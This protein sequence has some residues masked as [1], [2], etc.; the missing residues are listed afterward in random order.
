M[1]IMRSR[2]SGLLRKKTSLVNKGLVLAQQHTPS[3]GRDYFISIE[4]ERGSISTNPNI[5]ILVLCT[6]CLCAIGDD[7]HFES[8]SDRLNG[9]K[10][11]GLAIQVSWN[12]SPYFS[13]LF[14]RRG[15]CVFQKVR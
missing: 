7:G 6:E 9:I 3:A 5:S 13:A 8:C 2:V 4:G 10:V 15:E 12:D 11:A 1:L 14:S